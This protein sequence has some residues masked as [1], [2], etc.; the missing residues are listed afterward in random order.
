MTE[1]LI[2]RFYK[3]V[4][5]EKSDDG[6]QILLDGRKAKTP[7]RHGLRVEN[8]TFADCIA[9]EWSEQEE[10]VDLKAMLFTRLAMSAIDLCDSDRQKII[11]LVIGYL[12]S[13]LLCYF[14]EGPAPLRARQEEAWQPYLAWASEM[15]FPL[16]TSEGI[17]PVTQHQASLDAARRMVLAANNLAVVVLGRLTELSGSAVLALHL[18]REGS[19]AEAVFSASRVDE[20][21]QAEKWGVDT[22]A[23]ARA[24]R[25]KDEFVET[26]KVLSF[27][28]D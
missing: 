18:L 21:F 2:K 9:N 5:V 12:G 11:D 23:E 7:A 13:D 20:D 4:T 17:A 24:L 6:F 16:I 10:S 27:L 1:G 28:N 19:E 22:E 26:A 3:E 8:R 14:S 15:G 25:L